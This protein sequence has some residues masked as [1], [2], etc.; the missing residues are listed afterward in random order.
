MK[1]FTEPLKEAIDYRKK[2]AVQ[3]L[4]WAIVVAVVFTLAYILLALLTHPS[5]RSIHYHFY[6]ERGLITGMSGIFLAFAGAFSLATLLTQIKARIPVIWPWILM[7][8]G[9]SFL[10]LDEVVQFHERLGDFIGDRHSAGDFRNW[11]DIIVILYGVVALPVF[12]LFIPAIA[13]YKLA[14][15]IF[16]CAFLFYVIHT[17]LDSVSE[18]RTELSVILEESAKLFCGAFLALGALVCFLG[19]LWG[20]KAES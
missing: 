6:S 1:M 13:R 5:D 10:A 19:A 18:P 12:V 20:Q 2:S 17:V 4:G 3:G 7:V 11:N 15:E 16:S 9:F 8:L 14:L